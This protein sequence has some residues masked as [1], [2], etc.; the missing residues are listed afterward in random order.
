[1]N[2]ELDSYTTQLLLREAYETL[3]QIF[4]HEA[5]QAALR[6]LAHVAMHPKEDETNYSR[7]YQT[8]RRYH[9]Q[10]L[11]DLTGLNITQFLDQPRELVELWF[12]ISLEDS[13]GAPPG[14]AEMRAAERAMKKGQ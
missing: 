2:R 11:K 14:D 5:E 7:L 8:I 6:P 4:D 1:M 9:K 12:Q 10:K 3:Y 13:T